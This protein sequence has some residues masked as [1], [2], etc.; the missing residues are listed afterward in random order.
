MSVRLEI[1]ITWH[2]SSGNLR[3]R[4]ILGHH[5][6]ADAGDPQQLRRRAAAEDDLLEAGRSFIDRYLRSIV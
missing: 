5:L 1:D 2:I 3:R 4:S 6:G